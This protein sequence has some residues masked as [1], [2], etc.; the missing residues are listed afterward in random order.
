MVVCVVS[1]LWWGFE[2]RNLWY[3]KCLKDQTRFDMS[4]K[5]RAGNKTSFIPEVVENLESLHEHARINT[6]T[7][8]CA[9]DPRH[10][11]Q[12]MDEIDIVTP[13]QPA[14]HYKLHITLKHRRQKTEIDDFDIDLNIRKLHTSD[15]LSR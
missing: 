8:C 6:T 15:S 4:Q 11:M 3:S 14:Y 2:S 1:W 13:H 12:G 10:N 7:S 5:C 9:P